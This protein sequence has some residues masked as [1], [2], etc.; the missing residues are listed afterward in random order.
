MHTDTRGDMQ[1]FIMCGQLSKLAR[2]SW[3][4]RGY[5]FGL[6]VL[7]YPR[8]Y[9]A[10]VPHEWGLKMARSAEIMLLRRGEARKLL[11][12]WSVCRHI[13]LMRNY[14]SRPGL[15]AAGFKVFIQYVTQNQGPD[16]DLANNHAVAHKLR[17][18]YVEDGCGLLLASI[19]AHPRNEEVLVQAIKLLGMILRQDTFSTM[20]AKCCD[21][22]FAKLAPANT[23]A[24]CENNLLWQTC[25]RALHDPFASEAFWSAENIPTGWRTAGLPWVGL[26]VKPKSTRDIV[27]EK[28][29]LED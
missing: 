2:G 5:P 7:G 9:G 17:R 1:C 25:Q 28:I 24:G 4:C 21:V 12:N 14:L 23:Q 13:T 11:D 10:Y 29:E 20:H 27:T 22:I 26:Q 19:K 18:F 3:H 16:E 6:G 15:Q 8:C